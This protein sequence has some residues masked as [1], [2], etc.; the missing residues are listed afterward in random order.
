MTTRARRGQGTLEL[1]LVLI[2]MASLVAVVLFIAQTAHARFQVELARALSAE[3]VSTLGGVDRARS[4]AASR[5]SDGPSIQDQ[6]ACAG[7]TTPV[8]V[9]LLDDSVRSAEARV[10]DGSSGGLYG[11]GA[12]IDERLCQATGFMRLDEVGGE[13]L[14]EDPYPWLWGADIALAPLFF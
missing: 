14:E 11:A 13:L 1:M 6:G 7:W 5:L 12:S 3:A 9:A 10:R 8:G 4:A 2:G